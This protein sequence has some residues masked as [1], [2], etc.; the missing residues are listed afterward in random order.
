MKYKVD[1]AIIMAAGMSS[2]FAPLSYEKPKGLMVVKGEV[3]IERQIRQL[4]EAGIK[5]IV[6]VVGYKKERF[7]YLQEKYGVILVDNDDYL[8]RNNN[9]SLFAARHYLKNSYICSSDNY[10]IVNPFEKEVDKCYYA[11]VYIEGVTEE[12]CL[13]TDKNDRIIN[14]TIGGSDAWVMLGHT[15]WSREFS[16]KFVEIL[17]DEYDRPETKTKLWEKIYTEHI[18]ELEMYIKKYHNNE[19]FE[20]DSLDELRAFDESYK[21]DT[22]SNIIKKISEQMHCKEAEVTDIFPMSDKCGETVGFS[23]ITP[24]G[25]Y[26]YYYEREELKQ[27]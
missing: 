9:G 19:I 16:K 7:Q 21:T 20:F 1:N 4:R 14:V 13:E 26:C 18:E 27:V 25:K 10:F 22:R 2:R 5:E 6:I 11:S 17:L 12:W 3:L 15:F 23:F 8:T 24:A